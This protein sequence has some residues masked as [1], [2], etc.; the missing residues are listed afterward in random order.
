MSKPFLTWLKQC[1]RK[2]ES[3][4]EIE[5][6]KKAVEANNLQNQAQSEEIRALKDQLQAREVLQEELKKCQ[7]ELEQVKRE[8]HQVQEQEWRHRQVIESQKK[9]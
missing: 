3:Y 9:I 5:A 7:D 1:G 8:K 6:L 4:R 2:W